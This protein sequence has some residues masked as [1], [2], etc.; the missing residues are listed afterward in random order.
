MIRLGKYGFN[1]KYWSGISNEATALIMHLLDVDPSTR[2]SSTQALQSDWIRRESLVN[3]NLANS[4]TG[5]LNESF[6]LKGV[7]RSDQITDLTSVSISR[8]KCKRAYPAK[9]PR[10]SGLKLAEEAGGLFRLIR[11]RWWKWMF[12]RFISPNFE[13]LTE[14]CSRFWKCSSMF[15]RY[16]GFV[17]GLK[18]AA[19]LSSI[20]WN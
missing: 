5:I 12:R 4:L 9:I 18:F 14:F 16:L 2:L 20:V 19:V 13:A 17:V 3:N 15:G 10:P 6:R 11:K 1:P 7:V 8:S